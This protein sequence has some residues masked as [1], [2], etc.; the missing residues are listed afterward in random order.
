MSFSKQDTGEVA[1]TG[2]PGWNF[3]PDHAH[4]LSFFPG[5]PSPVPVGSGGIKWEQPRP[6][7]AA[8]LPRP[9]PE[10]RQHISV[11]GTRTGRA[12]IWP[13]LFPVGFPL[14]RAQG[15]G[16]GHSP[17]PQAQK[18]WVSSGQGTA[19]G[20]G[21]GG[22]LGHSYHACQARVTWGLEEPCS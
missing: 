13:G 15:W 11:P 19:Q 22:G 8:S 4:T 2:G 21:V 17:S 20:Q 10:V 7:R 18:V 9:P 3:V 14:H 1:H 12:A 16:Q 5:G 6:H